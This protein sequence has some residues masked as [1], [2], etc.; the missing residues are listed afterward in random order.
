MPVWVD[1][2]AH[3]VALNVQQVPGGK[4]LLLRPLGD[5]VI[6]ESV[7]GMGFSKAGLNY[8]RQDLRFTLQEIQK[9]FPNA[10]SRSM[11][12]EEIFHVPELPIAVEPP[13]LSP[14]LGSDVDS[15]KAPWQMTSLEWHQAR[16]EFS[17]SSEPS[18]SQALLAGL[19][20]G[21]VE[22]RTAR[23]NAGE[24]I[25][26]EALEDRVQHLDVV[27]KAISENK[28]VPLEVVAEYP[29][30]FDPADDAAYNS[31]TSDVAGVDAPTSSN[32]TVKTARKR[33]GTGRTVKPHEVKKYGRSGQVAEY[34]VA[35]TDGRF[36][37]TV[38]ALDRTQ[39][40]CFAKEQRAL[41]EASAPADG[42][43]INS[44]DSVGSPQTN[45]PAPGAQRDWDKYELFQV[46]QTSK[47]AAEKIGF[48]AD[49][50][51]SRYGW[52]R[53][54]LGDQPCWTNRHMV[55]LGEPHY[56]GFEQFECNS[57]IQKPLDQRPDVSHFLKMDN[58]ET[59][60]PRF[61][62]RQH[63]DDRDVVLFS[64]PS[65]RMVAMDKLYY[66]Y[67]VSK[68]PAAKFSINSTWELES[69][70]EN[71]VIH[72]TV[73]GQLVS[74]VM[75]VQGENNNLTADE[76][77]QGIGHR[78]TRPT[79]EAQSEEP[80]EVFTLTFESTQRMADRHPPAAAIATISVMEVDGRWYGAIETRHH[81]GSH[82]G[83]LEA[84][85][86][87]GRSFDS[88]FDAVFHFGSR[89][90]REQ[91]Q[92]A[93]NGGSVTTPKQVKAASEMAEW[94]I[95]AI[96]PDYSLSA[97]DGIYQA[98]VIGK[99]HAG[100]IGAGVTEKEALENLHDNL[101]YRASGNERE[102]RLV[103]NNDAGEPIEEDALG[104]RSILRGDVR[105]S[106]DVV[107]TADGAV[108][109]GERARNYLTSVEVAELERAVNGND[110]G[111]TTA[112]V[113]AVKA[114]D[115][116]DGATVHLV[117]DDVPVSLIKRTLSK[118]D[119]RIREGEGDR[120]WARAYFNQEWVPLGEP[121]LKRPTQS[122][123]RI[124]IDSKRSDVHRF[125]SLAFIAEIN[126]SIRQSNAGAETVAQLKE[127]EASEFKV[128]PLDLN[129]YEVR[130]ADRTLPFFM[131]VEYQSPGIYIPCRISGTSGPKT[132]LP[133]SFAWAVR[134]LNHSRAYYQ[135]ALQ[136][137]HQDSP[138]FVVDPESFTKLFG[139]SGDNLATVEALKE[140]FSAKGSSQR[141]APQ[142]V[143][144]PADLIVIWKDSHTVALSLGDPE[145]PFEVQLQS[146]AAVSTPL[147]R[148]WDA[149]SALTHAMTVLETEV[150]WLQAKSARPVEGSRLDDI[151]RHYAEFMRAND[152]DRHNGLPGRMHR[153][154]AIALVDKD[155]DHFLSW[156]ARPRG[157]NDLSKKFFTQMTGVKLPA[158]A[159]A[160]TTS[161]YEWAGY[162][163]AQALE[164]ERVK[165]ERRE[166]VLLQ[167]EAER[168]LTHA[169]TTLEQTQYQHNGAVKSAK[170]FLDDIIHDGYDSL[171]TRKVGAVDQYR[172]VNS[173]LGNFYKVTGVQVDYARHRLAEIQKRSLVQDFEDH[174]PR[175]SL[176]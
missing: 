135:R 13:P 88:K 22:W 90:V 10:I 107:I 35:F 59:L 124:A 166:A 21:V 83:R 27:L 72:A 126:E 159:S 170:Q 41:H 85:T 149:T 40:I 102:W 86:T 121:W 92:I 80:A 52:S 114:G 174:T 7:I 39:A 133:N 32:A 36:P 53:V 176:A 171:Q 11:D 163:P 12:M 125:D 127:I 158:T 141:I 155:I 157:Q 119:P 146:G 50:F 173:A 37:I 76:I 136:E 2:S 112:V 55:D 62:H 109:P 117:V 30:L 147:G 70:N 48:S 138:K 95:K 115:L 137:Q 51:E 54:R 8:S 148:A 61:I 118:Y 75:P 74:L 103:G 44:P 49:W 111:S 68:H 105:V 140:R 45:S 160:I 142:E 110:V 78:D 82:A 1:L 154:F 100:V 24:K 4:V 94:A 34:F 47:P 87:R 81:Q 123:L 23:A 71:S 101:M 168:V 15:A 116:L 130:F 150:A 26:Q 67:I 122:E 152:P 5:S 131:I 99:H 98:V 69:K 79:D 84:L 63:H 9:H 16:Q 145:G 58:P 18:E 60:Q 96:L 64:R 165:R 132:T 33:P 97:K 89:I 139:P 3:G 156:L 113:P 108:V 164:M 128:L 42:A 134:E 153:A 38:E 120:T 46:G 14:H 43:D 175:P 167:Q 172:L 66:E 73:D 169:I 104:A 20:Y 143:R 28:A 29:Q 151:A 65:G 106:E 25:S 31:P 57:Y 17:S 93:S 161:I 6:P 162:T 91:R 19:N 144:L 77:H 56:P 129:S